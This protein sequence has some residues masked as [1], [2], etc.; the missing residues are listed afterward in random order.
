[1]VHLRLLAGLVA[2]GR[3][4]GDIARLQREELQALSVVPVDPAADQTVDAPGEAVV[5]KALE[6]LDLFDSSRL[7]TTLSDALLGLGI[8][9]F[10]DSVATPLLRAVGDRWSDGRLSIADEHLLSGVLR[11][12][13]SGIL[14]SRGPNSGQKLLIASPSGERHE[15]GALIAALIAA[16][17]GLDVVYLG[18]DTPGAELADAADR[19]NARAVVLG[20]INTE[21][22]DRA[23]QEIRTLAARL[24]ITTELW[25]GGHD[26]SAVAAELNTSSIKVIESLEGIR[27]EVVRLRAESPRAI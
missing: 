22:H 1:V 15:F 12:M 5:R 19:S 7:H 4:I 27:V 13:F 9:R 3:S 23:V 21:N 10:I 2:N 16:D 20:L 18:T 24:P 26:A 8:A 11:G 17:A 25:I 14:H 6:A